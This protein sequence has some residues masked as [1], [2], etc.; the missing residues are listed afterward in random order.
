MR[1]REGVGAGRDEVDAAH[2]SMTSI[3]GGN[4]R[5]GEEVGNQEGI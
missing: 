2:A 4:S 1:K 3:R 5:L